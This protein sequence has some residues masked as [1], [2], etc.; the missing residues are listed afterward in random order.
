MKTTNVMT[1]A[2]CATFALAA[3]GCDADSPEP[4]N[5][6]YEFIEGVD[7][8]ESIGSS[9]A[10]DTTPD[11]PQLRLLLTDAPADVEAVFVTFDSVQ[12]HACPEDLDSPQGAADCENGEWVT[13]VD[14]EV[15]FELLSL[16]GGVTAELGMAALP[17]GYYGQIR[18][19]LS[20]ASVV[21][22][23]EEFGLDVPSGVLKLNGG[24]DLEN[25]MATEVTIDFDAGKSVHRTGNGQWK[26]Q[27]VVSIISQTVAPSAP[28]PEPADEPAPAD[29]P[30]DEPA[31]SDEPAP[32]DEPAPSDEPT[33]EP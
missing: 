14:E 33:P 25:G 19:D 27:P 7:E 10:L 2:L 1:R 20:S 23:G 22:D 30:T 32:A 8:E 13:V 21:A 6:D 9:F 24:F 17:E 28:A 5:F 26:M 18:L 11:G 16:Q 12:V 29:E 31:P 15:T 4:E 3:F